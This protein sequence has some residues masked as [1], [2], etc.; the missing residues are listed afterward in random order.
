[1]GW[2][3][4]FLLL[5]STVSATKVTNPNPG[6]FLIVSAPKDAK[7]SYMKIGGGASGPTQDNM[8]D[9]ITTGLVHPQGLA[10]DQKTSRLFVADPDQKAIFLYTLVADQDKLR[11][12]PRQQLVHNCES[13]WVT[14]DH[15]GNIFFSD[16]PRNQILKVLHDKQHLRNRNATVQVVLD[17]FSMAQVNAPGGVATDSFHTYWVNKQTG[18]QVG[19][20]VKGPMQPGSDGYRA[21]V[22]PLALNVDKSYGICIALN[23]VYFT[24]PEATIY[25]VKKG[26]ST[27]VTVGNHLTNPRGCAWDGDG[28]VYVAD[29][30]A[31]AVYSFASNM[32]DLSLAQFSKAVDFQDAY[33]VAVFSSSHRPLATLLLSLLLAALQW[34][35]C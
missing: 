23:N 26:G 18:T 3:S 31:G 14:A 13:R 16:E 20:V 32:Q 8:T 7:V 15:Y 29:R 9:L 4:F 10:V 21:R 34:L 5:C 35:S 30:G 25:G 22:Q 17:G 28:T 33:G 27:V 24:Q 2:Q 19:S 6:K 1:M 11:V 12:G